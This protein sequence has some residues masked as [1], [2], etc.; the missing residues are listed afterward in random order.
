VQI[1]GFK[2]KTMSMAQRAW[3]WS[4]TMAMTTLHLTILMKLM[5]KGSMQIMQITRAMMVTLT[6]SMRTNL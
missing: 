4:I 3:V 5:V 2:H 6:T 1:Q